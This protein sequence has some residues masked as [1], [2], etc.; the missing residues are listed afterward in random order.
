MPSLTLDW[1]TFALE[2]VNFLILLW[3]LQRFLYRPIAASIAR[4]RAEI[5]HE[6]ASG[7]EASAA[8]AALRQQYEGRLADWEREKA[9]A[10]GRLATDLQAER[11]RLMEA[12]SGELERE[13]T[14]RE[15]AGVHEQARR[16][17]VLRQAARRDAAAFAARL[18]GRL[19]DAVLEAKIASLATDDL[20]R[21]PASQRE[22]LSSA[23]GSDS[24]VAQV[25]SA[26]GSGD[27]DRLAAAVRSLA[28]RPVT[29]EHSTDTSL[30]A[31]VRIELGAWVLAANL[32]DELAF[33]AEV[34]EHDG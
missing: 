25:S 31:G 16:E 20:E 13:R 28:G 33:F 10:R 2:V 8:A 34:L 19:A 7:R 6:L 27:R 23:L 4:R 18:L 3:L 9:E 15:A 21:L 17:A 29:L 26:F 22:S 5:D 11:A 14:R 30:V 1:T 24:A 32:R 12:L